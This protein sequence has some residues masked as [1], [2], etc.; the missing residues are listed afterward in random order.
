M[1]QSRIS[2]SRVIQFWDRGHLVATDL[3]RQLASQP[4][5]H[6]H[7]SVLWDVAFLYD[8]QTKWGATPP[9]FEG[10]PVVR[11]APELEQKLTVLTAASVGH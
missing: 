1:V 2:D 3:A 9:V 8:R 6:Q 4:N 11:A 7:Q 10:G 5:Y